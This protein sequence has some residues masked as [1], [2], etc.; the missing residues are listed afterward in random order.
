MSRRI[1]NPKLARLCRAHELSITHLAAALKCTQQ[2][3]HVFASGRKAMPLLE[4]KL[5][6]TFKL[7]V[8][9]F[10]KIIFN[11]GGKHVGKIM[12]DNQGIRRRYRAFW[13]YDRA[14]GC[15]QWRNDGE[16]LAEDE[17]FQRLMEEGKRYQRAVIK[18]FWIGC[19]AKFWLERTRR[20]ATTKEGGS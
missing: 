10:R 15:Q 2:A 12:E 20:A 9:E 5:A 3:I 6:T 4:E 11:K 7:K 8:P 16:L 13:R 19:T 17:G 1:S 18:G 14:T